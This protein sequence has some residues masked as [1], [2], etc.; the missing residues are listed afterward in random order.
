MPPSSGMLW[1]NLLLLYAVLCVSGLFVYTITEVVIVHLTT[2]SC[3]AALTAFNGTAVAAGVVSASASHGVNLQVSQVNVSLTCSPP[4]PGRRLS[5]ALGNVTTVVSG[6]TS[7]DSATVCRC[8]LP[9]CLFACLLV[10]LLACLLVCLFVC[11]FVHCHN[12]RAV[13]TCTTFV[14][15]R[16]HLTD[17]A[18]D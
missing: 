9:A 4:M 6:L 11:L 8:C 17:F 3:P 7:A 2:A 1:S 14:S 5:S 18:S 16:Y 13:C 15:C 10:C 12:A